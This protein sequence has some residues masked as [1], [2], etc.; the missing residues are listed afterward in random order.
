MRHSV[1]IPAYNEER[2]LPRLLDSIDEAR[3]AYGGG[4][5]EIE[6][7][8]A[9]NASTDRTA[10]VAASRGCRVARVEKRRIAAARNG[11]AQAATGEVLGFVD[12]DTVRIDPRTFD[13][14]DDLL[15]TGRCV[16]GATGLRPERWSAGIVAAFGILVPFAWLTRMDSGL[17]FCRRQDWLAVGG[18]DESRPIAEDIAFLWA[19]RRLGRAR[20]QRLVRAR[21]V[22]ATGS[23]R[24]FDQYGDWHYMT[25]MPRVTWHWVLDSATGRDLIDRYWYRPRR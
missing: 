23:M 15:A 11:G 10:E 6:V 9:D 19:L 7:V 18:Y 24:K 2:Y 3:A 5:A 20:G 17:V 12:A 4:P 13:V 1:I 21:S 16:A 25:L 22:K 14:V 8:V